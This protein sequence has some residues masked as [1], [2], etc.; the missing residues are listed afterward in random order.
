MKFKSGVKFRV[1]ERGRN[2][3]K[4]FYDKGINKTKNILEDMEV[5]EYNTFDKGKQKMPS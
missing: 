2:S 4:H 3:S 1:N 5:S